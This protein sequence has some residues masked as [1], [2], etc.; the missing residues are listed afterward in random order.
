MKDQ[1]LSSLQ[2]LP[3]RV[4]CKIVSVIYSRKIVQ[5]NVCAV[6]ETTATVSITITIMYHHNANFHAPSS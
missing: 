1:E 3:V 4:Y 2:I 5:E 6:L